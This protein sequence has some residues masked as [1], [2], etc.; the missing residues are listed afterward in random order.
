MTDTVWDSTC[1]IRRE[2]YPK[3]SDYRQALIDCQKHYGY[4]IRIE[5]GWKFFEFEQDYETYKKQK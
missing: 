5:G 4:Q 2:N 3:Q 1:T